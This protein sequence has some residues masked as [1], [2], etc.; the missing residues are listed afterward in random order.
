MPGLFFQLLTSCVWKKLKCG[1]ALPSR[2]TSSQE[3]KIAGKMW[4]GQGAVPL[5]IKSQQKQLNEVPKSDFFLI[6]SDLAGAQKSN[7]DTGMCPHNIVISVF[8]LRLAIKQFWRKDIKVITSLKDYF[9]I[10]QQGVSVFTFNKS[11][12]QPQRSS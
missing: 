10:I 9:K 8:L 7:K 4:R 6:D 1:N 3:V 5:D 12:L 2:M 11:F